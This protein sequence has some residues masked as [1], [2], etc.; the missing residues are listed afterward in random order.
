[1]SVNNHNAV[2]DAIADSLAEALPNRYVQRRL[3]DPGHEPRERLLAG[4]VCLVSKGGGGFANYRGREGDLGSMAT[5]LVC[6]LQVEEGSGSADIER[7][8]LQMLGELLAWINTTG[9]PG[10][11]VVE[12]GDWTQSKQLEYPYGW[13]VLELKVKT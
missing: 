1:M 8:E 10:L 4:V 13:L 7:A 6:F 11:D 3:A 2:L 9:V 5:S 12:A